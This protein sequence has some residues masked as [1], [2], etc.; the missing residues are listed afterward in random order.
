MPPI[1]GKKSRWLSKIGDWEGFA[2]TSAASPQRRCSTR[3]KFSVRRRTPRTAALCLGRQK[4]TLIDCETGK[5]RF[6][7][8]LAKASEAWLNT[9]A[10]RLS[11]VEVIS[12]TPRRSESR[13]AKAKNS[14]AIR[15]RSSRSAQIGRASCR[16]RVESWGVDVFVKKK[17]MLH[18]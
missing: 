8:N 2:S 17:D 6:W 16:E 13:P 11:T 4:S 9:G 12:K 15:K 5:R 10:Y 7:K 1:R 18:V 14:F 3:L